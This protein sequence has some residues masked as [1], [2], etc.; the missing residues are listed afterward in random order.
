MAAKASYE[1]HA[2]TLSD[3]A[4][5]VASAWFGMMSPGKGELT[6]ELQGRKPAAWAQK[7]LN[8]LVREGFVS[9]EP[10]NK[11]GGLVY[12]PMVDC[13]WAFRWFAR[14]TKH[15]LG[16]LPLT[17]AVESPADAHAHQQAALA[18]NAPAA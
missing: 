6:F 7:G 1:K 14:N 10:F 8:E 5:C 4:K 16:K 3:E 2:A 11:Y 17:D 9:V 13:H 12:R 18:A 15:P